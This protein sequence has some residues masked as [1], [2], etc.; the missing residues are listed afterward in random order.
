MLAA[1]NPQETPK[2]EPVRESITVTEQIA[3]EAPASIT[4]QN[5]LRL[6]ETPGINLDDR[7]RM[8]P[9]FSLFRRSSSVVANPTTQGVSLRGVGSTGASRTLVLWDGVPVND[10]FG[11]WIYWTRIPPEQ[12]DRVEV[13]RGASTSVFG[14]RAMSGAIALFS[15][16]PRPL[17][18]TGSW[19]SG[20]LG[21]HELSGGASHRWTQFGASAHVRAFTTNGYFIIPDSI[22]GAVDQPA[23]VRFVAGNARLDW[24]GIRDRLFLKLDM[25]AEDRANGTVLQRNSTSLGT[26]AANYSRQEGAHSLSLLGYHTREEFRAAFS[27]IAAD[28]NSERLTFRQQVPS[29]AL[30]GAGIWRYSHSRWA[31]LLGAD[32]E[33][34][35]GTSTDRLAPSGVRIGGGSR[36]R[37][38]YFGQWNGTIGPARLY[39]GA[40]QQ[41]TGDGRSFF[42]PSA[43]LSGS[44]GVLRWRASAYRA[45]RAPTL[46]ELVR[47]FRAGNAQ[48]LANPDLRPETLFGAEA[49]LDIAGETR[50]F[51]ITFF[52]NGLEDLITNVTLSSSPNLIVR[53]RQNAGEAV[54]RGAEAEFRQNWRW[55]RTEL[56]YLFVDARFASGFRLP[57]VARHQ[58]S[59]QVA[60]EKGGLL[61]SAGMRAFSS[62][63]EDERNLR[64]QLMGGFATLMFVAR[65]QLWAGFSA[66]VQME[67]ALDREFVVGYTPQPVVGAPRLWR[68]GLRWD[69][70]R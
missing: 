9:G 52:R 58:G 25:I 31:G 55:L 49:G 64:A 40:R 42:S 56:N 23:G 18:F 2:I 39:L 44:R 43:G 60:F 59:A 48:T 28:R 36:V 57:Q 51:S 15:P 6:I 5:Q 11:G 20:N 69:S 50:R 4:V 12:T 37:H 3:A 46:N 41:Y 24:F 1:Q 62:Q 70:S 14:D 61:A 21:T 19:E 68:A 66:V 10:P 27:A 29:E 35:E 32:A 67:N 8:V 47:E 26:L 45:F 30:G 53:Q 65:Q 16:E 7:L 13:S 17:R 34:V 33:R 22:R 38:G 63:F 54:T